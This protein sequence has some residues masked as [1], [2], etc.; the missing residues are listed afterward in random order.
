MTMNT[1]QLSKTAGPWLM[2]FGGTPPKTYEL[3]WRLADG[4]GVV[5]VV[6]GHKMRTT[7]ALFDEFAAA[8]QFPDYFGENWNALDECLADLSWMPA[9]RYVVIITRASEVLADE[10]KEMLGLLRDVLAK[11]GASLAEPIAR[12]ESWDRPAV[13]FH[14]VLQVP[15]SEP[16][17]LVAWGEF[18]DEFVE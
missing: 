4:G 11:A 2:S 3:A 14:V 8:L 18:I 10:S 13:P 7:T 1:L 12:G 6:R 17:G 16:D 5:R 15:P 9:D